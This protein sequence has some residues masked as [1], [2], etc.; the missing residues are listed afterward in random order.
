[1]PSR[2]KVELFVASFIFLMHHFTIKIG[3]YRKMY[4]CACASIYVYTLLKKT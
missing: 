2:V 1:M 3:L 4:C